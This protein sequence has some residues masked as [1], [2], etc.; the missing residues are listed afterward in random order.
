M[1]FLLINFNSTSH[2]HSIHCTFDLMLEWNELK[3][4]TISLSN[5]SSSFFTYRFSRLFVYMLNYTLISL[6][7]QQILT[8]LIYAYAIASYTENE[9]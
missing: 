6:S 2:V 7:R 5:Y 1:I 8:F 9:K 4:V 3:I